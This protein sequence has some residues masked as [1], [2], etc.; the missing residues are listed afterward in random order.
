MEWELE[1]AV[2][3][4]GI[5]GSA[6]HRHREDGITGNTAAKNINQ[7]KRYIS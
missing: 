1:S 4:Q 3:W 6:Y 7:A 5:E 2:G